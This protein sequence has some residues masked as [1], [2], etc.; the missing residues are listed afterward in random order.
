MNYTVEGFAWHAPADLLPH[1]KAQMP[2]DPSDA[3][4]L[5][6]SVAGSG[7]LQPLLVLATPTA[8]GKFLVVDGINRLAAAPRDQ[9]V[10]C[11]EI[12]TQDVAAVA[13]ECLSVGRSRSSGQRIMIYLMRHAKNVLAASDRSK[14]G[15]VSRETGGDGYEDFSAAKI[16]KNL[17]VS[18]N[19]VIAGIDL[20]RCKT[21]KETV[22]VREGALVVPPRALN[23]LDP[24]DK[25]LEKAIDISFDRILAGTAPIRKWKAAVGGRASTAGG[26]PEIDYANLAMKGLQHLRTISSHWDDISMDD[27]KHILGLA[28]TVIP[29]LPHD[30]RLV[31]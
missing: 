18:R 28:A 26:R 5:S 9:D 27:R 23:P 31:F 29:K 2:I 21:R 3:K 25:D 13:Q 16:A 7:I 22:P 24:K 12:Q 1:P 17:E 19:D 10:P 30:L 11:I 20:L 4:A 14:E 6:Q 8:S 15:G